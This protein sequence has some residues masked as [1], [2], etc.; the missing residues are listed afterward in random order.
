V[1]AALLVV[2]VVLAALALVDVVG[3]A[4]LGREAAQEPADGFEAEGAR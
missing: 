3:A 2:A 1:I 4:V